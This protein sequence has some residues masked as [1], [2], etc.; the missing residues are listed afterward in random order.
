[1]CAVQGLSPPREYGGTPRR[2]MNTLASAGRED[3]DMPSLG[4]RFLG[5][6]PAAL[7]LSDANE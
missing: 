7:L 1:M 2:L 6:L 4:L 3:L 5:R